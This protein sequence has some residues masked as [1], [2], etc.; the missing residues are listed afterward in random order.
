MGNGRKLSN[1]R[2]RSSFYRP[3]LKRKN[4]SEKSA[5]ARSL[6][7]RRVFLSHK[8]R[9]KKQKNSKTAPSSN[10]N[11][12]RRA[13]PP[14]PNVKFVSLAGAIERSLVAT[15]FARVA[16]GDFIKKKNVPI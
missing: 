9:S 14:R 11:W 10:S 3:S 12:Q 2:A 4:Q 8:R 16:R 5:S 1:S 15:F 6:Q 13:F 7:C